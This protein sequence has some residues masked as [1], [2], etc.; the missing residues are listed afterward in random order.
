MNLKSGI[1]L[2]VIWLVVVGGIRGLISGISGATQ[3][4]AT[5]AVGA[6]FWVVL[7]GVFVVIVVGV[8][9]WFLL[10]QTFT[11]RVADGVRGL[12]RSVF[13]GGSVSL[14]KIVPRAGHRRRVQV[15]STAALSGGG[16]GTIVR[17]YRM[18]Y[19]D[20]DE[21]SN[22]VW[23]GI[24]YSD[25]S[26]ETRFGRVRDEANLA[27]SGKKFPTQAAA[28]NELERKRREK[29]RKGYKD[30]VVLDNHVEVTM[31]R[32]K[33]DHL[34]QIAADQIEGAAGDTVTSELIKYLVDVNIHHIT[35]STNIK[36]NAK[37]GAF[38]TPLGILTPDAIST[39]R[40]LL[41]E[42]RR[43]DGLK[44]KQRAK[45]AS[46]VRDYFQLVPKDFGVRIPP[47]ETL[48][49]TEEQFQEEAAILDAL[50]SALA[51]D[52]PAEV[53]KKLFECRLVKVPH[54]T[55]EGR[56]T[57]RRV[58]GL[59]FKTRNVNHHPAAA[60]LQMTRL[61]EVEIVEM[62]RKFEATAKKLG[63][64]RDDL[65]HGT[66][67]SNLLSI[68][69]AG[70]VIPPAN[71]AHCTGR[72]FGNGIYTSLQSTKALNYATDFWNRSGA[73]NQRTFMFLC[74]VAL[75]KV[76]RSGNS[77][78]TYPVR[79]TNTTWVEPGRGGV[80]NHECIVYDTSQVNLR[81]LAE[82]GAK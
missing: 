48:I 50:E 18:N 58:S 34:A 14:G 76:Y 40:D 75:G 17:Q 21:N 65:W 27:T 35:H 53:K 41:G 69:R 3:P 42:L 82:F 38:S 78:R 67:A 62:K 2:V 22:K 37:T 25:G 46:V 1:K 60:G 31:Q 32:G 47:A 39:A 10:P 8:V 70:L 77:P 52:T 36:Y 79:G 81:Y 24:A 61:Y 4:R 29:L 20:P 28:E 57:F 56:E 16:N 66:R 68:L 51:K 15:S 43:L 19:F 11:A 59:Y 33:K 49:A 23:I 30:T 64:V 7:V 44:R 71:A 9:G 54:Y 55:D 80:L 63:N 5:M 73:R 12:L 13:G 74:D 45:R 26:F 72:M 6:G